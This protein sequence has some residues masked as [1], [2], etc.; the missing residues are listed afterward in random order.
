MTAKAYLSELKRLDACIRQKRM[1]KAALYESSVR[2]TAA[3][4]ERV[5]SM[6]EDRMPALMARIEKLEREIDRQAERYLARKHAII[7]QIHRLEDE[8][9][10][11]LLFKRYVE[12][13]RLEKIAVEMHYSYRYVR[14]LHGDAL[15]AFQRLH[16]VAIA[17]YEQTLDERGNT[18]E[19]LSVL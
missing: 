3:E 19:H 2:S 15:T 9:H 18:K 8:A 10:I 7:D 16:G 1:E 5:V 17:D 13:K 6:P 14:K 11:E 12:F 4:Q